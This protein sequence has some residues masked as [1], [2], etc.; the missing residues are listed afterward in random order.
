MA[1]VTRQIRTPQPRCAAVAENRGAA[2]LRLL[3]F[4]EPAVDR[5]RGALGQV[6]TQIVGARRAMA[7]IVDRR[8]DTCSDGELRKW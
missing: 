6:M 5:D 1:G 3:D 8:D 7:P 4:G 2:G